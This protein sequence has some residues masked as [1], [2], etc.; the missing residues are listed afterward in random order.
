MQENN[1]QRTQ[2]HQGQIKLEIKSRED[3]L[4]T[5]NS[6]LSSNRMIIDLNPDKELEDITAFLVTANEPIK[7]GKVI[8]LKDE[9]YFPRVCYKCFSF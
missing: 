7:E 1:P 4:I 9:P 3:R 8:H 5:N 6:N 2:G